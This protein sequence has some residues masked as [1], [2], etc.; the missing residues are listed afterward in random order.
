MAYRISLGLT[1]ADPEDCSEKVEARMNKHFDRSFLPSSVRYLLPH[2]IPGYLTSQ[3]RCCYLSA[4][5]LHGIF[6]RLGWPS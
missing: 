2:G 3:S 4:G 1:A 5:L 6:W